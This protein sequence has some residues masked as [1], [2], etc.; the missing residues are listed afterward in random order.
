LANGVNANMFTTE[1]EADGADTTYISV[2]IWGP[3]ATLD[4]NGANQTA[5]DIIKAYNLTDS[6]VNIG[7]FK[8]AYD[9]AVRWNTVGTQDRLVLENNVLIAN[10]DTNYNN[11]DLFSLGGQVGMWAKV[12][13]ENSLGS[14][15]TTGSMIDSHLIATAENCNQSLNGFGV[16]LEAFGDVKNNTVIAK[17]R[18]NTDKGFGLTGGTGTV[19]SNKVF[20][21]S[22]GNGSDGIQIYGVKYN[23]VFF[24]SEAN[25]ERGVFVYSAAKHNICKGVALNN[26]Q[27]GTNPYGV[28]IND[29][30]TDKNKVK[31]K[32]VDDQGTATQTYGV[33]VGAGGPPADNIVEVEGGGNATALY[34][35][36]GTRT[37]VNGVGSESAN[38]ETPTAASW[39]AGDVVDFTDTG[40]GSGNGVYILLPDGTWSQ[41]GAT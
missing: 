13:A 24:V 4:G 35:D 32:A 6:Y 28:F 31:V 17:A 37:R 39:T 34:I 16:A 3:E 36:N 21:S 11:N 7:E 2:T 26:G 23:Q 33:V 41:I 9:R 15:V 22:Y 30:G 29:A 12:R 14:G 20:V 27:S 5:G 10:G 40:D 25:D 38:A 19:N 8:D 1:P 18:G